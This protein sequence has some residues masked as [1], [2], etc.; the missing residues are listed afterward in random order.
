MALN[1]K[2]D[3]DAARREL[4]EAVRLSDKAPF[5]EVGEARTVLATL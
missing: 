1:A 4:E 2:G 3:R 5:A